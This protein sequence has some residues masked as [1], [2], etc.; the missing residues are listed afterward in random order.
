MK[1]IDARNDHTV[2]TT[3]SED[4]FNSLNPTRIATYLDI[5]N[6]TSIKV[7]LINTKYVAATYR[8]ETL[9]LCGE[10]KTMRGVLNWIAR[11]FDHVEKIC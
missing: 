5:D 4:Q 2:P 3:L 11:F 8:N 10:W 6:H 1:I 7:Y 9:L